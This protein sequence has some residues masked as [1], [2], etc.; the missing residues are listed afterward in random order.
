MTSCPS[1]PIEPFTWSDARR[2]GLRRREVDDA[3][4]TG[5]LRRVVRDV[6]VD[7][8]VLDSL[9]LRATAAG[10]VLADRGV[11][12]DRTAAWLHG[13]DVLDYRE[14]EVLPPLECVVLRDHSRIERRECVGGERDLARF[15]VTTVH[16]VPV[17]T[18]LRTALD[19]GCVLSRPDALAAMDM[20][21]RRHG[22]TRSVLGSSLPR[23]RRRRGVVQLRG[24]VP[25]VDGRS[26]SPRESR[27][28]LAVHDAGLP[29][30]VPQFW[31]L[32]HGKPV[33][34]LDLAYPKHRIAI[35]YDGEEWH[36]STQAQRDHDQARRHWL[37]D[38]GWTVIVVRR[39]DF[40]VEGR[41]RW[42]GELRDA[43]R[44][45]RW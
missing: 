2:L 24:L 8:A 10:L 20:F 12:V 16:G 21:A 15:D 11:Y 23:Y 18:P 36:D 14:L 3:V 4:R 13:V 26:E 40:S 7:A 43:L 29:P 28:R 41:T 6:Y 1:F 32:H 5:R 42:L 38:R 27:T 37:R 33:F 25:L 34:R 9:E 30:L 17:T 31:V 19:L 35:E 22:I 45:S 39:G 44:A